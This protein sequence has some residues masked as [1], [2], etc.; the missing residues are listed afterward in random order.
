MILIYS[1]AHSSAL[2]LACEEILLKGDDDILFLYINEPS[3]ILGSNQ[4]WE[5]EVN[6][7]FCDK[8]SIQIRRRIS[9]G[10]CVY[11]DLGNLNFSFIGH[12]KADGLS[13]SFLD[14]IISCLQ[15]LGIQT[16]KGKRKDLW[17]HFKDRLLKIGG[18]ASHASK[19]RQLSHGTL[20]YNSNLNILKQALSPQKSGNVAVP[21]VRS[22]VTNILDT[23]QRSYPITGSEFQKLLQNELVKIHSVEASISLNQYLASH[24]E[25]FSELDTLILKHQSPAYIFRK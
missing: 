4:N 2:H 19:T 13:D 22:E 3:V 11:H 6:K 16:E 8:N 23:L 10:G 15:N 25:Q 24:L 17:I 7:D 9:G 21:S 12:K 14:P 1:S 18:T 20:L 5:F